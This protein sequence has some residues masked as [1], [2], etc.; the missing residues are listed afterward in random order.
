VVLDPKTGEILAMATSPR[1]DPNQYWKLDE[2]LPPPTRYNRA[3]S[4]AI[5]PGSVFKI[6]T[7]SIALDV[8][9]VTPTTPFVDT[10]TIEVGGVSIH[11]WDRNAWGLQD[12][13]SCMEHSLN[14]CL[15]W[16]ATQIGSQRFYP[17]L[18]EFGVGRR[19]RVDMEGEE[20]D[21]LKIPGIEVT[22]ANLGTNSF[23]QGVA[24]TPLQL[25]SAS[26]ALANKGVIMAPHIVKAIVSNGHQRNI[27][28]VVVSKPISAKTAETITA[29]LA[30]TV[31]GESYSRVQVNDIRVAGK[32]GTAEIAI[33]GKGYVTN[34]TNA[35]F[36]GWGPVDD[37]KFIM[38]VWLEKP[39]TSIWGSMVA[40]PIFSDATNRL[41]EIMGMPPDSVRSQLNTQ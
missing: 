26:S 39:R 35:S 28:P 32:T 20:F 16:V 10:G 15:A 12:M 7:M 19:S 14:V 1:I 5:E 36:I 22:E 3:I 11:D 23:G 30:K 9:A 27:E 25:I 33:P 38:Y 21:P 2:I 6:L 8:G 40:A 13:T 17:Y 34:L 37:P 29:M 24:V 41:V 31:E 18:K 4:Q